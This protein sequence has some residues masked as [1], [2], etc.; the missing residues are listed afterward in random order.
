MIDLGLIG[1]GREIS[2]RAITRDYLVLRN[3][4]ATGS[5]VQV[6]VVYIV[7]GSLGRADFRGF[8]LA[9][10]RGAGG[11]VIVYVD[12]PDE[13]AHSESPMGGLVDLARSAIEYLRVGGSKRTRASIDIRSCIEELDRVAHALLGRPSRGMAKIQAR[14][15]APEDEFDEVAAV[16]VLPVS[17]QADLDAA[18]DLEAIISKQLEEERAG[19]VDGNQVGTSKFEIFVN[20]RQDGTLE[21]TIESVLRRHWRGSGATLHVQDNTGAIHTVEL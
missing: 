12:V 7:P 1:R 4:L 3:A 6:E 13:I 14:H 8:Q 21:A 10:R 2:R 18:F 9:T 5:A 11:R 17:D 20:G 15:D 19:Y 16:I